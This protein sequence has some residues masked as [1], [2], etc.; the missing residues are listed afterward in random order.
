MR[1]VTQ[2]RRSQ[3][4][5]TD[6]VHKVIFLRNACFA[7]NPSYILLFSPMLHCCC[8]S[9]LPFSLNH[10]SPCLTPSNRRL[11]TQ[12]HIR[13]KYSRSA[14]DLT[15]FTSQTK[16]LSLDPTGEHHPH[17][18]KDFFLFPTFSYNLGDP[19]ATAGSLLLG[20]LKEGRI[21]T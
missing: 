6:I 13:S 14:E 3:R 15:G 5:V 8:Q 10:P 19:I 12:P 18:A 20:N 2:V 1:H 21:P 16:R 11:E 17:K 7:T 9:G 4:P